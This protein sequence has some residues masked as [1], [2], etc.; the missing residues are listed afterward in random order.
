MSRIG[1]GLLVILFV[2]LAIAE[3]RPF[4]EIVV[5]GEKIERSVHNTAS[6]VGVVTADDITDYDVRD[7]GAALERLPN[8]SSTLGGEAFSIR[9]IN[10][11]SI[12]GGNTTGS[13]LGSF[14]ID[15]ANI[16][17]FGVRSG[18]KQLWDVEQIEVFRGAQSTV[19]GR[20]A[21][22]GLIAVRTKDPTFKWSGNLRFSHGTGNTSRASA[23]FGGPLIANTLAYR[24]AMD[25]DNT[26]GFV[27]NLTRG[28]R[29][30]DARRNQLLRGKLLFTPRFWAGASALFTVSHSENESG[31]DVVAIEAP[32]QSPVDPYERLNFSNVDGFENVDQGIVSLELTLPIFSFLEL[33]SQSTY[34]RVLYERQDD[35]DQG[36]GGLENARRR[37]NRARTITQEVRLELDTEPFR[38]HVGGYFF[39]RVRRDTSEFS[40]NVDLVEQGVIGIDIVDFYTNPFPISRDAEFDIDEQNTA[41]FAEFEFRYFDWLN[42]FFGMRYDV[43]KQEYRNEQVINLLAD[44][45]DPLTVPRI[46]PFLFFLPETVA[47]RNAEILALDILQ[48]TNLDSGSKFKA[49]LPRAGITINWTRDLSTGFTAKRGYRA[50]GADLSPGPLNEFD[51]EFTTNYEVFLRSRWFDRRLTVNADVF[52]IDW[53]DQQVLVPSDFDPLISITENA[54]RSFLR[55]FE[56]ELR[57]RLP[58]AIDAFASAGYVRAQFGEFVTSGQ[59]FSG[60]F[61]TNAPQWTGSA[62]LTKRWQQGFFV[63]GDVTYQADS[64]D[65]PANTRQADKR[66]LVN[67]NFGYQSKHYLVRVYAR[68]LFKENYIARPAVRNPVL[69]VGRPREVGAE[70]RLFF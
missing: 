32:N 50:G 13:G 36:A 20:N 2:R 66:T 41:A 11:G 46:P 25:Y 70:I 38:A 51:P 33:R 59:D 47:I 44:L 12:A 43:E 31:D 22:A 26:D 65:D 34:N 39:K 67:A 29:D 37:E 58:F 28:D 17:G 8:V 5:V 18:Q 63:S 56:L 57:G 40:S 52:Y 68:N 10:S 14:Y 15:G 9:G 21:L 3:E 49:F 42:L 1:L 24:V 30:H 4:E 53:K 19:Q 45:P 27:R 69:K 48:P 16:S 64:F 54:G 62:G 61:F 23:A 35:D 60:N 7:L 55:G 6:S